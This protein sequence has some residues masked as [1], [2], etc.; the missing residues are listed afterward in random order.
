MMA[1]VVRWRPAVVIDTVQMGLNPR[2]FESFFHSGT[3]R[4]LT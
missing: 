2:D 1:V 4:S 3:T